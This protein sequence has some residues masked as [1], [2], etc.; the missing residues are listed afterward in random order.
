MSTFISTRKKN[1]RKRHRLLQK[2]TTITPH[3]TNETVTKRLENGF[4]KTQAEYTRRMENREA[5]IQ[6][7]MQEQWGDLH[8]LQDDWPKTNTH[9][10]FRILTWNPDGISASMDLIDWDVL[11]CAVTKLQAS[12]I[13][14]NEINLNILDGTLYDTLVQRAKFYDRN[15]SITMN[16]SSRITKSTWYKPGGTMIIVNGAW[17]GRIE[18]I[19]EPKSKDTCGR[20]S[21]V[22]LKQANGSYFTII[23]GYRVNDQRHSAGDS[24]IYIQQQI[25]LERNLGKLVDPRKQYLEDLD[26]YV[27]DLHSLG[28]IVYVSGDYNE[29]LNKDFNNTD[30]NTFL[31]S[32]SLTDVMRHRHSSLQAPMTHDKGNWLETGAITSDAVLLLRYCGYLPFYTP[33]VSDHRIM[34]CDLDVR[35]TFGKFKPD[36]TRATY[37]NF[38]TKNTRRTDKYI[39]ELEEM[40]IRSKIPPSYANYN[41]T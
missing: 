19:D 29:H 16:C 35:M 7:L 10:L 26:K 20:W 24:T 41:M 3:P 18:H 2:R 31:H 33:I 15:I 32:T 9:E 17:S 39:Q 13:C 8:I 40:L 21:T 5:Q 12:V 25:D 37:K 14:L 38:H 22:H 4:K 6:K 11:L 27:K 28:H 1:R 34:F 23:S 30:Y 36:T